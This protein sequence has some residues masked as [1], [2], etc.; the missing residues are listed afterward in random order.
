[1]IILETR[2]ESALWTRPPQRTTRYSA[3]VQI[4]EDQKGILKDYFI[5]FQSRKH[6]Y[7]VVQRVLQRLD[8]RRRSATSQRLKYIVITFR[9]CA[10]HREIRQKLSEIFK[11]RQSNQV[12]EEI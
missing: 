9:I 6:W 12:V 5:I 7:L 11:A 10:D 3:K 1:M 8:F 4:R 2:D